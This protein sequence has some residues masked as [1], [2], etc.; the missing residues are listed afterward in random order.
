MENVIII[1]GGIAAHSAAIYTSR[2]QLEPLVL[3][4]PE[5]DQLSFTTEVENYPGFPDGI[6]GPELV[7]NA[8]KQAEKFGARYEMGKVTSVEKKDDGTFLVKA[9]EKEYT[10][11]TVIVA[12]GAAARKLGIPGEDD[13]FGKGVSSCAVCDAA[14]YKDKEVVIVGGGDSAMEEA[15]ILSKFASKVTIVHRRDE[16]RASKIMQK[17]VLALEKVSVLWDTVPVEVVGEKLVTGLKIK[18]VKTNEESIYETNGIFL[19]IGHIPST[20][21]LNSVVALDDSGY[22]IIDEKAATSVPGIFAAGDCMDNVFMQAITSAGSG[23][24][25]ALSAERYIEEQDA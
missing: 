15:L 1:G 22:I 20:S 7:G 9:G 19:A 8:K 12:T 25:A 11:K 6:Q 14:F 23:A 2:A 3:F 13:F 4:A 17:K 24:K 18:N 21:F 10:S 5:M 16:F